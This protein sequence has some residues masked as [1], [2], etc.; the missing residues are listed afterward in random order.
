MIKWGLT[1]FFRNRRNFSRIIGLARQFP[2]QYLEIRGERPFFS[3]EDLSQ[4]DI[5]FF[6][7]TIEKAGLSV[8]LHATFYD[9][10]LSTINSYLK[11]A[12]LQCYR[13]YLD[14]GQK[15]NAQTMVIHPGSRRYVAAGLKRLWNLARS[16]V[17][18]NLQVLGD[19]AAAKN[20]CLALENSPPN[21][22]PLL[23]YHWKHHKDII[24]R[25]N[26]PKVRAV[27][28]VA[29]A[30]LHGL[31][32]SQ[33]YRNIRNSLVGLHIHNNNGHED[34][35]NSVEDGVIDFETFFRNNKVKV[36]VIMEIRNVAEAVKSLKWTQK[37]E[38]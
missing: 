3:P 31:D 22:N 25:V 27:L 24:K 10:N 4:N 37:I 5:R 12:T 17:V 1:C 32:I 28:D 15:I 23:V 20:I 18:E 14:L 35:H 7:N 11:K 19:Y 2:L 21:R 26:H 34:L 8:T 36:P 9:I 33:Y 29:H 38:S 6:G 30:H 16:N 13:R